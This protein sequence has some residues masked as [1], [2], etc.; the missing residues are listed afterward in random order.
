VYRMFVELALTSTKNG[1][2]AAQ[3]VP[4][5]LYNGANAT[6]IRQYFFSKTR[7]ERLVCFENT[8]RVWFDI[9]T[10]A[11][12]FMYVAIPGGETTSFP[13][14][15]GVS[16]LA[17]LNALSTGLPFEI[18]ITLVR[19]FSPDALAI[20]EIAHKSDIEIAKEIYSVLP[21]FVN[22][23]QAD[24]SRPYLAELHMG[25]ER[26][27]YSS[28]GTVPVLEGRMIEAF[29]YRTK[30]YVS[31][32]GR[33]ARWQ[34][35]PFGSVDKRIVP[36]WQVDADSIPEK[37]GPR[38]REYRIAFCN[39]GGVTNQRYLM[40]SL[41]PPNTICGDSVPT[42]RFDPPDIGLMGLWLG[43]A[44]SFAL[45]Y[46][47][48]R[49]GALHLTFTVM[50]SLPLPTVFDASSQI[51]RQIAIRSLCLG[52]VGPEM[53]ALRVASKKAL[54]LDSDLA[55]IIH[56]STSFFISTRCTRAIYLS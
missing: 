25:N 29:D 47:A 22:Y 6:A 7:F 56:D 45:D 55:R 3:F 32:R 18:P 17:K 27:L 14:A 51:H 41:V 12:F 20:S 46:L 2:R 35:L 54:Q 34:F 37:V 31:G 13:A 33:A 11:K 36:Q 10:R 40:A 53:G 1:G 23:R 16:S 42:V 15:F 9:D 30:G 50:D 44:N 28:S 4:D 26:G 19:E 49:K 52:A 8:K 43:T 39:V 38:W 21:K 24:G 5:N 48:R